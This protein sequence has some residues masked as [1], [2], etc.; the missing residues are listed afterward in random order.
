MNASL[1]YAKPIKLTQRQGVSIRESAEGSWY[2]V[3][4][5]FPSPIVIA[6]QHGPKAESRQPANYQLPSPDSR[7]LTPAF[8]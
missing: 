8:Q 6:Q 7:L 2:F 1:L 5:A 3:S 4:S